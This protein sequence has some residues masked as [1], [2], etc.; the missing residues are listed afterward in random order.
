MLRVRHLSCRDTSRVHPMKE[1]EG[2]T[3][4]QARRKL[5]RL[6]RFLRQP[7]IEPSSNTL[8]HIHRRVVSESRP[9]LINPIGPCQAAISDAARGHSRCLLPERRRPDNPLDKHRESKSDMFGN[10]PDILP[11]DAKTGCVAD[12]AHE[13]PE[14][15]R[16]AVRDEESFAV[17]AWQGCAGNGGRPE[18]EGFGGQDMRAGDV[19]H[20]G[21]VKEIF[22]RTDLES[23]LP[24][25]GVLDH[26]PESVRVA[27]AENASW[28]QAHCQHAIAGTVGGAD[29]VVGEGFGVAVDFLLIRHVEH[30]EEFVG[31]DEVADAVV[32]DGC[33]GSVD[34]GLNDLDIASTFK[35]VASALDVDAIIE[36]RVGGKGDRRCSVDN[37]LRPDSGKDSLHVCLDRDVGAVVFDAMHAV[38]IQLEIQD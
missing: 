35:E 24:G 14:G 17:D 18:Q 7:P 20:I 25:L 10:N 37:D 1:S 19:A 22:A 8:I 6:L 2:T 11:V 27:F 5:L 38:A 15:H 32:H 33:A 13:V 23:V 21:P 4:R 31:V 16:V 29:K 9:C 30:G 36:R 26:L 3:L 34:E 12:C 28:S